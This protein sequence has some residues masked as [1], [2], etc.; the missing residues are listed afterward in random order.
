MVK[1]ILV[2]VLLL[3]TT[4]ITLV[5]VW[6]VVR[7][8]SV[9]VIQSEAPRVVEKDEVRSSI[10][11][12]STSVTQT[13]LSALMFKNMQVRPEVNLPVF[14][15]SESKGEAVA[16]RINNSLQKEILDGETLA[17]LSL[18]G[19]REIFIPEFLNYK[20]IYPVSRVLRVDL[21]G[22]SCGGSCS[23]FEKSYSFDTKTGQ[24]LSPTDIFTE[25]GLRT[26]LQQMSTKKK[27]DIAAFVAN[28]KTALPLA[29][30]DEERVKLTGQIEMYPEC[31]IDTYDSRDYVFEHDDIYNWIPSAT[32]TTFI[33]YFC[34]G[35]ATR[36]WDELGQLAFSREFV[37]IND[38]LTPLGKELFISRE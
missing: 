18:A 10:E 2:G 35:T 33:G 34:F 25:S 29:K 11:A 22:E 12:S 19:E 37:A 3:L 31:F 28:A 26:L 24:L 27:D 9:P 36:A 38:F 14:M 13:T 23:G 1:N 21:V 4:L 32:S 7:Q 30:N 20:V 6:N 17:T 16:E 8:L 5:L 15:G